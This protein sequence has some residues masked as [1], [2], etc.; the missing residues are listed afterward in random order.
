MKLKHVGLLLLFISLV[1]LVAYSGSVATQTSL[2]PWYS[3]L[4]KPTWTPP[5]WVFPVV[6][7]ILYLMIAVAGWLISMAPQSSDKRSALTY[8]F[9]QLLLNG[10]WSFSFF[11][12]QN[13][14][15]GLVNIILLLVFLG[16][17]IFKSW[18]VNYKAALLLV[19]Y[20]LW[21]LYAFAL[22]FS[23]AL[24]NSGA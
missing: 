2:D 13:P 7:P 15:L 21:T 16:L 8:F 17:T 22:N 10:L 14:A 19:P 24:M 1:T 9:L 23:I 4:T 20:L 3:Q 18:D 12:F 11:Y 5:S 6:W